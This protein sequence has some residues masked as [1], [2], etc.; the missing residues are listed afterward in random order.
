MDKK[1]TYAVIVLKRNQDHIVVLETLDFD[2]AHKLYGEL[3]EKWTKSLHD[4]TPFELSTPLVTAFD[5]GLIYEITIRP[6]TESDINPNNPYRKEMINR[7]FSNTFNKNTN[8]I[9]DEGYKY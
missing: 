8:S 3:K 4:Q 9:L 2:E 7:G 5:P 6:I 1:Q